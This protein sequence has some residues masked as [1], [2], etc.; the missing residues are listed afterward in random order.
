MQ[1]TVPSD[2]RTIKV[3]WAKHM[4]KWQCAPYQYR[5]TVARLL[6]DFMRIFRPPNHYNV[7]IDFSIYMKDTSVKNITSFRKNESNSS[8]SR[9]RPANTVQDG[10]IINFF[11]LF[12]KAKSV[13]KQVKSVSE[14]LLNSTSWQ[15]QATLCY[16]WRCSR[17]S[18]EIG[19]HPSYILRCDWRPPRSTL[20]LQ[21]ITALKVLKKA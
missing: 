5:F 16:S 6:S 14:N 11:K 2:S 19:T 3:T 20:N 21:E 7:F 18:I 17:M 9:H 4:I 13:R 1:I 10:W 8:I 15:S 12:Y